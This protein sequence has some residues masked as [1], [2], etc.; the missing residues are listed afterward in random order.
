LEA[1]ASGRPVVTTTAG[2]FGLTCTPGREMLVA[3][4]P[5]AFCDSLVSALNSRALRASLASN[6]LVRVDDYDWTSI[7]SALR[8]AYSRIALERPVRRI[9][10][11][12]GDDVAI[13]A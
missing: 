13:S 12:S 3:D 11:V 2:A 8:T 6:A 7:G 4:E 10:T 5:A 9:E 1:W